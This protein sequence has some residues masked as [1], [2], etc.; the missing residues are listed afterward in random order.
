MPPPGHGARV[1]VVQAPA[2]LLIHELG[3]VD[4]I[5]RAFDLFNEIWG[6]DEWGAVPINVMKAMAHA[7]NYVAGAWEDDRLVGASVAFAWGDLSAR[8][9]HSHISGVL[10][11]WQGRGIGFALKQHQRAWASERGYERI[12]WT[13]DPLVQRN[14]WFNL[15]KLGA[16][17]EEYQ[18]DFY[19]P[20]DDGI[21]AGDATDRCLAVWDVTPDPTP[22]RPAALPADVLLSCG[23]GD[24]PVVEGRPMM[25]TAVSCQ[26]P[27]DILAI[28]RTDPPLALRWRH[29]LRDTMGA[30]I[31]DGFVAG[32]ITRDG[33]YILERCDR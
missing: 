5:T 10:E 7:G 28:R 9:L 6:G 12:T 8:T 25:S 1:F 11:G 24:L 32:A 30:A 26:I 31:R 14:A 21:N 13:F 15:T 33:R 2:S 29:A 16:R 3:T 23:D 22:S 4:E 27:R 20:M 18:P 17:I 19:G